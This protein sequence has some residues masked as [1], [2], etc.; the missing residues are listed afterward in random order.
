MARNIEIRQIYINSARSYLDKQIQ[1]GGRDPRSVPKDRYE[2]TLMETAASFQRLDRLRQAS[3][4]AEQ[5]F[6]T[7][8]TGA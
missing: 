8:P 6:V 5:E 3:V 4:P 1:V 2:R 7:G